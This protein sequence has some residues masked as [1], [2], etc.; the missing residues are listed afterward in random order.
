MICLQRNPKYNYIACKNKATLFII[1]I[2]ESY[3]RLF[4]LCEAH[5]DYMK[6]DIPGIVDKVTFLTEE[7]YLKYLLIK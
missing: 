7:R 5:W 2:D 3:S 4:H 1:A 6:R